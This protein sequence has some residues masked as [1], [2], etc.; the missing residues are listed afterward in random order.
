MKPLF[1]CPHVFEL[2]YSKSPI[3]THCGLG[4]KF[5][6]FHWVFSIFGEMKSY[7]N[8][9]FHPPVFVAVFRQSVHAHVRYGKVKATGEKIKLNLCPQGVF[10]YVC[11]VVFVSFCS[12]RLLSVTL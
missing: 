7:V 8:Q 6:L 1:K 3:S 2:R 11:L 5:G 4:V 9:C 12:T 10:A